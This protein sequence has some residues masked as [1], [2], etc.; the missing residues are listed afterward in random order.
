MAIEDGVEDACVGGDFISWCEKC[1]EN[2]FFFS[3][4]MHGSG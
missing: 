2:F 3:M 4:W 1:G